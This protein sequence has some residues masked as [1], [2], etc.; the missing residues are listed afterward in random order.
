MAWGGAEGWL[1]QADDRPAMAAVLDAV[2]VRGYSVALEPDARRA[3]GLVLD[4]LA[5]QPADAGHRRDVERIVH[6]LE[7]R[8]Y[9]LTGVE[10]DGSYRVS[11]IAAPIFGPAGDVILALT[12]VGFDAP[13]PAAVLAEL[14]ERL[15]DTALVVTKRT[16]GRPPAA[17]AAAG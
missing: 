12:L 15:R 2:R 4:E 1:D 6:D 13:V 7:V 9:Q 8:P 14:G 17:A 11:M 5:D 10:P 16:R 3:L